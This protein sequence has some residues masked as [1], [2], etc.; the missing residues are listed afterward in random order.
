[1]VEPNKEE[2]QDPTAAAAAEKPPVEE[3]KSLTM[4]WNI[5]NSLPNIKNWYKLK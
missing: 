3:K 4:L 2:T 1:M 5:I